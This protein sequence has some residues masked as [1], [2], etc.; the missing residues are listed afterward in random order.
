MI[1]LFE[2]IILSHSLFMISV[3]YTV[4]QFNGGAR[5]LSFKISLPSY[6]SQN[7][8]QESVLNIAITE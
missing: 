1:T 6:K 3:C 7:K 8:I 2:K 4:S 5:R